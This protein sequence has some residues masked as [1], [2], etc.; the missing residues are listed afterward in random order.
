MFGTAKSIINLIFAILT[1]MVCMEIILLYAI[2][3]NDPFKLFQ[4]R[5]DSR[6]MMYI[7]CKWL[8]KEETVC[9]NF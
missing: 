7:M 6:V 9:K 3:L 4:W 1:W 2:E 5:N 8:P